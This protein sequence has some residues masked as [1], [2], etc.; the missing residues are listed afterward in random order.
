MQIIVYSIVATQ[1]FDHGRVPS[2]IP[3][4]APVRPIRGPAGAQLCPAGAQPGPTWNAAWGLIGSAGWISGWKCHVRSR[5]EVQLRLP[6][7]TKFRCNSIFSAYNFGSRLQ[8]QA[9]Y[10]LLKTTENKLLVPITFIFSF[11][12]LTCS[13]FDNLCG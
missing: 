4:W 13:I 3:K 1:S 2:S 12:I 8:K 6:H 9:C 11:H 7:T 10:I 5:S